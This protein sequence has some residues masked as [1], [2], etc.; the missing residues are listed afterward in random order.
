MS[1]RTI[2]Q[3]D[4]AQ[5]DDRLQA[6]T[7]GYLTV[8]VYKAATFAFRAVVIGAIIAPQFIA[9]VEPLNPTAL[10]V[11]AALALGP[12]VAEGILT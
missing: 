4:R 6:A 12:D 3:H 5:L 2:I 10:L 11:L 9:G 8:E 7:N 1:V